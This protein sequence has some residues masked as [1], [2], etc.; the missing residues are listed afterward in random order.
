[1]IWFHD[2]TTTKRAMIAFINNSETRGVA[3]TFS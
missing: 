3:Q 2:F 1:M